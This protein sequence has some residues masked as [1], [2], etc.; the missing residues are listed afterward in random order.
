MSVIDCDMELKLSHQRAR[1]NWK[2]SRDPQ[3][4]PTQA[5]SVAEVVPR[6]LPSP[7]PLLYR[8]RFPMIEYISKGPG[9]CRVTS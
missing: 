8:S 3:A 4:F 2:G 1:S 9:D 7:T 5:D 6:F